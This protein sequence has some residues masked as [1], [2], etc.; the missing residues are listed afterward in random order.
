M[1]VLF[2]AIPTAL[3]IACLAV[4]AFV[5]QVHSGQYDDLDTPPYRIL[6]D[7]EPTIGTD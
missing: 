4:I 7:D 3:F 6:N 5:F 2:I 1:S